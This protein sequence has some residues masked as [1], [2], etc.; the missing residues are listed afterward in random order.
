MASKIVKD[1][2]FKFTFG[3]SL[4]SF[5]YW[6]S[7]VKLQFAM[8]CARMIQMEQSCLFGPKFLEKFVGKPIL[9][10]P[11]VAILE[12]IANAWD[13][14]SKSVNIVWPTVDNEQVFSIQDDGFG[15]T[16]SEFLDRWRT[17]GYDRTL[18]QGDSV[19]VNDRRRSVFGR[20]GVGRFAGF[21]FGVSYFVESF[22]DS[23][24]ILYEVKEGSGDS[25][26][27]LI[28]HE[29]VSNS[30]SGTR[31]FV[32]SNKP[33]K[34]ND[35]DV[36]AE[37]GMRFLTDPSFECYVNG[38]KVKFSDIPQTSLKSETL[39]L[40]SGHS[41]LITIIDTN[42]SDKTT[43]QHGVAWHVKGRL[44]GEANWK[45][46]GLDE[47]VDGRTVES[48]RHTFIVQADFLASSV[49]QDWTAFNESSPLFIET[50]N[51][52][53]SFVKRHLLGQTVQKRREVLDGIKVSHG[54]ELSEL[55]PLRKER[56]EN[57][58]SA[59]QEECT[60]IKE[61]DL[62][63]VAGVLIKMEQS[64][65]KYALISKLHE[66]DSAQIDDLYKILSDWTVDLAKEAL[67]ELQMRLKLLEEL[68]FRIA[69]P[70]TR[71]V[72]DLQPIFYQS[73][74]IFGPEYET[75][76]FTSNQGMTTVLQKLFNKNEKGSLNRPDFAILP[77]SS[78][79]SYSYPKYDEYGGEIGVDRV[80]IVELKKPGVT[81]SGEEKDQCWKYVR[82]LRKSAVVSM[83]TRITCF[84]L[85]DKVDPFEMKQVSDETCTIQ[86][87]SY[88][89]VIQRAK[90]RLLKLYDRV[91]SAPFLEAQRN[92][93]VVPEIQSEMSYSIGE[94]VC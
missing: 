90:S 45:S 49:K 71:E 6:V 23:Q 57:F 40:A 76:E 74:W 91:S 86:P 4:H 42:E 62:S 37:I 25:P 9:H 69:D 41:A 52:V 87:L 83:E 28:E 16:K 17:L 48:K 88:S 14:G 36:R 13:A 68:Q 56:F 29:P 67:D 94:S 11:K 51:E 15:L 22:K 31:I 77:D 63:K 66:L 79:G 43:K 93:L 65:S 64:T 84:V 55:S 50:K 30:F 12:L 60:T 34:I 35:D 10:D 27:K 85:G 44:V 59:V 24:H 80:V 75:I 26:F 89:I 78:L 8:L 19:I 38:V 18:S 92:E 72:Q 2:I 53:F 5:N 39:S 21:C 73:L 20:N 7:I 1:L 58:I 70:N 32:S 33:V 46:Y 61:S 3:K 82:E 54:K 81:I 47:I